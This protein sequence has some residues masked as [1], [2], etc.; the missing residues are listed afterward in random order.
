LVQTL[1]RLSKDKD[2]SKRPKRKS[3]D[4]GRLSAAVCSELQI[5]TIR[6]MEC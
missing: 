4:E 6:A 3:A 5:A 2:G 1:K